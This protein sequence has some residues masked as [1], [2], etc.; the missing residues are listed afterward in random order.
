MALILTNTIMFATPLNL[1]IN[2]FPVYQYLLYR[3][4][5]MAILDDRLAT[6]TKRRPTTNC[7]EKKNSQLCS[8]NLKTDICICMRQIIQKSMYFPRI[9][10][11]VPSHLFNS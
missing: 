8:F 11:S 9:K 4:R 6:D 10:I 7:T 3:R 5:F 1:N 2:F